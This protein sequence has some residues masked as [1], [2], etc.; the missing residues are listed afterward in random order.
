MEIFSNIQ[1]DHIFTVFQGT[2]IDFLCVEVKIKKSVLLRY[3]N[4]CF[5]HNIG[6]LSDRRWHDSLSMYYIDNSMI[7]YLC[8]TCHLLHDSG[9]FTKKDM[10]TFRNDPIFFLL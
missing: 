8:T 10:Q 2:R 6:G 3:F 5:M 7:P 1:A 4:T 9:L